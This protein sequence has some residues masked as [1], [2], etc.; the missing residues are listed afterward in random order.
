MKF[1]QNKVVL[2]TGAGFSAPA[3][4]PIQDRILKEMVQPP[5]PDFLRAN[6]N[7]E[8]VKFLFAY[9]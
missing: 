3:K 2:I 5:E 6:P 1:L 7:E 4:L 8:S 9:I